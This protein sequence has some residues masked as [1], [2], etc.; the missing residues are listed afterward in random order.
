MCGAPVDSARKEG[1]LSYAVGGV[2]LLSFHIRESE[3]VVIERDI[4][5]CS[6]SSEK[7]SD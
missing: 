4:I 6:S 5:L 1:R 7:P 3:A 2:S